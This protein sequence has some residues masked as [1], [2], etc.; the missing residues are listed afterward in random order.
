MIFPLT[1]LRDNSSDFN[2][3]LIE[4]KTFN[5]I[6]IS[7][8]NQI[9]L[10]KMLEGYLKAFLLEKIFYRLFILFFDPKETKKNQKIDQAW[11]YRLGDLIN[12]EGFISFNL[13]RCRLERF[14]IFFQINMRMSY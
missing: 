2:C 9:F 14:Q 5:F 11:I 13:K 3:D 4:K 6:E 12:E 1:L 10:L 7:S 8:L